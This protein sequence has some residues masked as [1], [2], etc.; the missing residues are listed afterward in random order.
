MTD[1]SLSKI[2]KSIDKHIKES[3]RINF[4]SVLK[5]LFSLDNLI[6][7]VPELYRDNSNE[8][9]P[10]KIGGIVAYTFNDAKNIAETIEKEI[11][12]RFN[13]LTYLKE[14]EPDKEYGIYV[15]SRYIFTLFQI[16]NI[17]KKYTIKTIPTNVI[18]YNGIPVNNLAPELELIEVYHKMYQPIS[19]E[20]FNTS[21]LDESVLIKKLSPNRGSKVQRFE[22]DKLLNIDPSNPS[23]C[24]DI[25]CIFRRYFIESLPFNE[26]LGI[27]CGSWA[28]PILISRINGLSLKSSGSKTVNPKTIVQELEK[29]QVI[30]DIPIEKF[31][32][33][34]SNLLQH[35]TNT[36]YTVSI[37]NI[38]KNE[39][40]IIGDSRLIRTTIYI[41]ISGQ[42]LP[43]IDVWNNTEYE[44]IPYVYIDF[45]ITKIKI[46]HPY[47]L[48]RLLLIDHWILTILDQNYEIKNIKDRLEKIRLIILFINDTELTDIFPIRS[49]TAY[50]GVWIEEKISKKIKQL[51]IDIK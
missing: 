41:N 47:V 48:A 40:P 23:K 39:L 51:A 35:W 4:N 25:L 30:T 26:N 6:F 22:I 44:L 32:D 5:Y 15:M 36:K 50:E 43:F 16:P 21:K 46:A 34:L 31:Q 7:S 37:S 28:V 14:F 20:D 18:K 45:L 38:E 42:S 8:Y 9:Y 17:S 29:P 24:K 10:T 33:M 12:V 3:D 11:N 2:Q 13:P 19:E 49:H 1:F 27:L